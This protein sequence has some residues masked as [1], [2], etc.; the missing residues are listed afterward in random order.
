MTMIYK[1]VTAEVWH[2]ALVNRQLDGMPVDL[3][4]GYIH[5]STAEQ[6][7]VTA[8]KHFAGQHDLLLLAVDTERLDAALKWEMSRGSA[9]FPHL[10][11]PLSTDLV[12]MVAPLPIGPD[13]HHILPDEIP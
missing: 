8:E 6:L 2:G 9:L 5:F 7:R 12:E 1:I 13:G 4:D 10:Y 11:A 3:R